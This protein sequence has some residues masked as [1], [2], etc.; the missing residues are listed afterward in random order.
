[1][2]AS[3]R[4]RPAGGGD[5]GVRPRALNTA[6]GTCL[7]GAG[8]AASDPVEAVGGRAPDQPGNGNFRWKWKFPEIPW[9]FRPLFFISWKKPSHIILCLVQGLRQ[10]ENFISLSFIARKLKPRVGH[11]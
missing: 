8:R 9:N 11:R 4:A 6:T 10:R 3:P 2:A 1:M 7:R 5:R